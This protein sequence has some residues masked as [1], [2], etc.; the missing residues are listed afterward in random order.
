MELTVPDEIAAQTG[1]TS[2]ELLFNLAVGLLLDGRLTLGRASLLAGLS[3]SAFIDELG[4]RHIPMPY[5]EKDLAED[6]L[7]LREIYPETKRNP[8]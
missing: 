3:K 5:D 7:T 1:C 8:S 6:L 2:D 4:R